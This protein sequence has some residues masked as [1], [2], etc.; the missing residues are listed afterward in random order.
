M[1]PSTLRMDTM[2][3]VQV[4]HDFPVSLLSRQVILKRGK[5]AAY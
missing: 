3:R 5:N 4:L 2:A 1:T